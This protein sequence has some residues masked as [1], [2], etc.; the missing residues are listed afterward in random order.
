MLVLKDLISIVKCNHFVTLTMYAKA[1]KANCNWLMQFYRLFSGIIQ[2]FTFK[3]RNHSNAS[4]K[5]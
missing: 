5:P 4:V 3:L 1:I 2:A